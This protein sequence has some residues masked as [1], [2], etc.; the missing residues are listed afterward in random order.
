MTNSSDVLEVRCY[1]LSGDGQGN[2]PFRTVTM[3]GHRFNP[4]RVPRHQLRSRLFLNG[5]LLLVFVADTADFSTAF[6]S[7]A[8]W[9]RIG[10]GNVRFASLVCLADGHCH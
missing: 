10:W 9:T 4:G 8:T 1:R 7:V 2:S 6:A 3:S 5:E